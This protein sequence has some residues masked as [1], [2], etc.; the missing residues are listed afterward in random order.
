MV[1]HPKDAWREMQRNKQKASAVMTSRFGCKKCGQTGSQVIDG[2][3]ERCRNK[4]EAKQEELATQIEGWGQ[5]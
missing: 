3:C 2:L 1:N 5:F 4:S